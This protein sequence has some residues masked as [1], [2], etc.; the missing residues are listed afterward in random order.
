MILRRRWQVSAGLVWSGLKVGEGRETH[1]AARR[2]HSCAMPRRSAA[3]AGRRRA[4]SSAAC[5]PRVLRRPM[6]APTP[7]G[8]RRRSEAGLGQAAGVSGWGVSLLGSPPRLSSVLPRSNCPARHRPPA[9]LARCRRCRRRVPPRAV[10]ERSVAGAGRVAPTAAA[11]EAARG[12]F[13]PSP[14]PSGRSRVSSSGL[15]RGGLAAAATPLEEARRAVRVPHVGGLQLRR[16]FELEYR[17]G[18][19]RSCRGLPSAR[20]RLRRLIA[21]VRKLP[22]RIWWGVG[23]WGGNKRGRGGGAGGGV[24]QLGTANCGPSLFAISRL[25]G[26]RCR[27]WTARRRFTRPPRGGGGSWGAGM[28]PDG[29]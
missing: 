13:R 3:L 28:R 2:R 21:V 23:W 20:P 11:G 4:G 9:S 15:H 24:V 7:L 14:D 8:S 17:W 6:Q 22:R 10:A 18:R 19:S 26:D 5:R 12:A 1:L 27:A 16:A 25:K 29:G